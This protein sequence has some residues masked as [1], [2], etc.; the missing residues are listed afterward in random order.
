V[1][2]IDKRFPAGLGQVTGLSGIAI[3]MAAL[4]WHENHV[5]FALP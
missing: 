2:S 5:Y 4:E 3:G 1:T